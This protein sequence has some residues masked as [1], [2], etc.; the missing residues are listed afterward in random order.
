MEREPQRVTA[1]E[2]VRRIRA[3]LSRGGLNH[4]LP[5]RQRDLWIVLHAIAR[6]FS[7]TERLTEIEA[8]ARIADFLLGPGRFL[9]LDRATL[10]RAMVDEGFLDRDP[11]GHSYRASPRHERRVVFEDPPAVEG[12]PGIEPRPIEG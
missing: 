10:R 2:Y 8:N 5:R 1:E 3:L 6:R 11:A 7:E 12:I 4:A 9:E